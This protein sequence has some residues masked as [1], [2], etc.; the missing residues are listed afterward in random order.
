MP[1]SAATDRIVVTTQP[2]TAQAAK[3]ETVQNLESAESNESMPK[4]MTGRV[5]PGPTRISRSTCVEG[6]R[7]RSL[8]FDLEFVKSLGHAFG[9]TLART[10]PPSALVPLL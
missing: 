6:H 7:G 8:G 10:Y 3:A 1:F 9:S 4:S 2:P 5:N